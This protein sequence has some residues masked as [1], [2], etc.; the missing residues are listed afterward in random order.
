MPV[1]LFYLRV[2]GD[3]PFEF[4]SRAANRVGST[5]GWVLRDTTALFPGL[6]WSSILV[7]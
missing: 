5:I 7:L 1:P 6:R 2:A 3:G 4:P